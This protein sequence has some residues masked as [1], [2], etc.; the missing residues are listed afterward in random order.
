MWKIPTIKSA[1]EIIDKAFRKAKKI[2]KRDK[3][4]Q[5]NRKKR[6]FKSEKRRRLQRNY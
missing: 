4:V 5:F 6:Y 3:K 1:D 2:K